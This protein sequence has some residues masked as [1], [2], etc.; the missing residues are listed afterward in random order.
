ML[1]LEEIHLVGET[2]ANVCTLFPMT[3]VK[4]NNLCFLYCLLCTSAFSTTSG[5]FNGGL[6]E[7][8]SFPTNQC[9]LL[10]VLNAQQIA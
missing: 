7:G 6:P 10:D 3:L 9:A 1:I 4:A 8:R 5:T 2:V